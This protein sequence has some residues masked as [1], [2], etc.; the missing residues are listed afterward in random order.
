[1]LLSRDLRRFDRVAWRH[2]VEIELQDRLDQPVDP[3]E[4]KVARS[5]QLLPYAR[6][7]SFH[8]REHGAI[9]PSVL[10]SR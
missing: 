5:R 8:S 1:M 7:P 4:V 9:S 10:P 3:V 6:A 2:Q